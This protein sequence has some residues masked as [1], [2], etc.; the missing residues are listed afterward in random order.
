MSSEKTFSWYQIIRLGVVQM[1]IGGI[2]VLMTSTLN[3]VM[4]VE[5]LLPALL[6]GI[7]V[8]VHY[9]VQILR[10]RLGYGADKLGKCTPWIKL[11]MV[12]LAFGSLFINSCLLFNPMHC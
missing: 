4:V 11:G 2:V 8:A 5:L 7:L 9:A 3:R 12:I 10:P 1:S 6:P